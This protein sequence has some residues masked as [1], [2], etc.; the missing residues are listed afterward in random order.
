MDRVKFDYSMKNIPVPNP[1]AYMTKIIEKTESFIRRMRWKAHFFL[2]PQNN[3]EKKQT[4]GFKTTKSPPFVEEMKNFEESMLKLVSDIKFKDNPRTDSFQ[5]KL[6]TDIENDIKGSSE[7]LIKADKTSNFYR[8]K[9]DA[10]DNMLHDNVTKTYR[11]IDSE[12][13]TNIEKKSKAIAE[14][15]N[16]DDRIETTAKNEPFIT[17]KDHKP[18]F[19][20]DPKCRLINP[21]KTEIGRVS[22]QTLDRINKQVLAI[23][24]TNLWKNTKEVLDWFK[25][26]KNKPAH[27]FISFDVVDYYPSITEELLDK[28][29]DFASLHTTMTQE[30]REITLHAKRSYLYCE[31]SIWGKTDSQG[32]FD[33]TMGSWDGAETCEFAGAYILSQVREKHGNDIGLYRDD[34]LGAFEATPQRIER[35]KKSLCKIFKDNGLK[36]TIEV[37]L[38]VVNF[39][40]ITL[41]VTRTSFAPYTMLSL[42]PLYISTPVQTIHPTSPRTYHWRSTRG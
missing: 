42:T 14:N 25:S 32:L 33:M 3:Q 7:M 31:D 5:K 24:N 11:K 19:D 37:N 39:L 21:T 30:E 12:A 13:V 36:I 10:Y 4:F 18:N 6:S 9:P 2:N 41:N 1:Q 20:M 17:L 34:G 8:M 28:A 29:L 16:L 15:F 40:D 23:T 22:K 27:E 35:I 38:D 26:I